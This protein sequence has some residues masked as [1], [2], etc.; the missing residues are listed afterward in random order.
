MSSVLIMLTERRKR[1]GRKWAD[2]CIVFADTNRF[3]DDDNLRVVVFLVVIVFNR[4]RSEMKGG[5]D[6]TRTRSVLSLRLLNEEV[7]SIRTD[8]AF[9]VAWSGSNSEIC[10][11]S[12][13]RLIQDDWDAADD[14]VS[15]FICSCFFCLQWQ[16]QSCCVWVTFETIDL[17]SQPERNEWM[18]ERER[19]KKKRLSFISK[20]SMLF[21]SF[22]IQQSA[23]AVDL[24]H[25]RRNFFFLFPRISKET[26]EE[27]PGKR[28]TRLFLRPDQVAKHA[29][30]LS[31]THTLTMAQQKELKDAFDLFDTGISIILCCIGLGC[32]S[33][34]RSIWKNFIARIEASVQGLESEGLRG[35]T[36]SFRVADG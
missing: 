15:S 36:R 27:W 13:S 32:F 12:I 22:L 34:S 9:H 33:S 10:R 8:W 35:S 25:C 6:D 14:T 23:V 28:V 4:S 16:R 30:F 7:I 5:S 21:S 3:N 26:K 19:N 31:M 20:L 17:L 1:D 2:S 29:I 18:I 24:N 11:W